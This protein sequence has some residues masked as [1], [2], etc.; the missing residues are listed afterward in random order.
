[1]TLFLFIVLNK[2]RHNSNKA[3]D[4][5]IAASQQEVYA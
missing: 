5:P 3:V 1:M 4:V 2:N